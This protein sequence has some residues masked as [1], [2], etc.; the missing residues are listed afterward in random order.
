MAKATRAKESTT[1]KRRSSKT[2]PEAGNGTPLAEPIT[3]AP[4]QNVE[5]SAKTLAAHPVTA[6][7]LPLEE[8]IRRRAYEIYLQ[9][10]GKGGSPEQ[11]WLQAVQ[12]IRGEFVT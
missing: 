6:E 7:Q 12:E 3:T 1:P 8:R 10:T 11:D 2:T 5:V 9:R 4:A